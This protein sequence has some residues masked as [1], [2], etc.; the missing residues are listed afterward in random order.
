MA[1][2]SSPMHALLQ[3]FRRWRQL[4]P[5]E[6]RLVF[7]SMLALPL[8]QA[9]LRVGGCNRA[10]SFVMRQPLGI[11]DE[12]APAARLGFLVHR[13]ALAILGQKSC[14]AK[15]IYLGWLLRRRGVEPR[16]RIGVMRT[17][18]GLDAHAWIEVSDFPVA[19]DRDIAQ[20]YFVLP[21]VHATLCAPPAR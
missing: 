16:L 6:R 15:S 13:C 21:D 20:R 1:R 5:P 14:L 9:C 11:P 17:P 2:T 4:P 7:A 10:W 12:D 3:N 18:E 8:V 19:E